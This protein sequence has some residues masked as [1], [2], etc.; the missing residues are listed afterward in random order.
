MSDKQKSVPGK[1][2]VCEG[3]PYKDFYTVFKNNLVLTNTLEKSSRLI[4]NLQGQLVV[5]TEKLEKVG[6]VEEKPKTEG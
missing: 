4:A 1:E 6:L 3:C 5:V 2:P